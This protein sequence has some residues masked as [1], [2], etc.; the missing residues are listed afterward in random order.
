MKQ[1]RAFTII[2]VLVVS[3]L[4]VF[5]ITGVYFL[6]KIIA[7]TQ[8]TTWDNTIKIELGNRII[9]PVVTEIRNMRGSEDGQ[10]PLELAEAHEIIFYSD[11]DFDQRIE[12]VRYFLEGTTLKKGIVEPS[13]NPAVYNLDNEEVRVVSEYISNS[14]LPIFYYYNGDWPLDSENNPLTF[15]SDVSEV[16]MVRINL[17]ITESSIEDVYEI[18]S[19]TSIRML[20][21]NL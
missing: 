3:T 2:E 13:G 10:Y 15:P 20:K 14:S 17:Q 6:Q 21:D 12:R 18:E 8:N 7:D 9:N 11:Y 5:L 1:N 16:K 19:F 4:S